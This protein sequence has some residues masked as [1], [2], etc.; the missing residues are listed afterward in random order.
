[1]RKSACVG[2]YQLLW[3]THLEV[4]SLFDTLTIKIRYTDI[5]TRYNP[6]FRTNC[7]VVFPAAGFF[8]CIV[9][10][11]SR[12]SI[13]AYLLWR[14]AVKYPTN[15][16]KNVN[17]SCLLQTFFSCVW[18]QQICRTAA[19]AKAVKCSRKLL[20]SIAHCCWHISLLI[21]NYKSQT[22]CASLSACNAGHVMV[23][24]YCQLVA[25]AC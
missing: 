16:P 21:V 24:Q 12:H 4:T 8:F 18:R 17:N 5:T 1:M 19:F 13:V 22:L 9:S 23:T 25:G 20:T 15:K 7:F 3:V 2:I 11:R 14:I 6:C 10:Y